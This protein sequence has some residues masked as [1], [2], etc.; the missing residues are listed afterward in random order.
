[1]YKYIHNDYICITLKQ[2]YLNETF[3]ELFVHVYCSISI[4]ISDMFPGDLNLCFQRKPQTKNQGNKDNL[5]Y[6]T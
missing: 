4:S 6:Q 5:R 2:G 1:M 3:H